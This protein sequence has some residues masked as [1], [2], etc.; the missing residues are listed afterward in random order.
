[1]KNY[2]GEPDDEPMPDWMN[3]KTYHQANAHMRPK[4]Y[5]SLN[6]AIQ[7]C[8]KKPPVPVIIDTPKE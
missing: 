6:E 1:M 8:L 2:W 4:T 7:D 3:P 5:K